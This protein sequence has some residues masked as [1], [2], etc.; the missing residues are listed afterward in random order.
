MLISSKCTFICMSPWRA[1]QHPHIAH[2]VFLV[3]V[4]LVWSC[5][6]LSQKWTD[7]TL[8]H[9]RCTSCQ[10]SGVQQMMLFKLDAQ[11]DWLLLDIHNSH[12]TQFSF[13]TSTINTICKSES[14]VSSWNDLCCFVPIVLQVS[15]FSSLWNHPFFT[16]SCVTLIALFFA[17]IHKRVVAPSMY[18]LCVDSLL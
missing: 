4:I 7:E 3:W 9:T 1:S 18:P 10:I 2:S 16:I 17:G 12:G 13:C 6:F 11:T 8:R 14:F 5:L 15:F